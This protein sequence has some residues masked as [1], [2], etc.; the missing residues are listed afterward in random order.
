M[1]Y[2]IFITGAS[3]YIGQ[4]LVCKLINNSSY[5]LLLLQSIK[6]NRNFISNKKVKYYFYNKKGFNLKKIFL[7]EKPDVVIHLAAK[8]FIDEYKK[9]DLEELINSNIIFSINL[10]DAM[11]QSG[12]KKIINTGTYWEQYY[13]NGKYHPVNFYA[14]FKKAFQD[15]LQYYVEVHDFRAI[16]LRLYDIYGQEDK[17]KKII[18]ILLKN[19]GTRKLINMSEGEQYV[20][21]I[22]INDVILSYSKSIEYVLKNKIPQNVSVDVGSGKPIKLKQCILLIEKIFQKNLMVNLGARPYRQREVMKVKANLKEAKRIINWKPTIS[23]QKGLNMIK[24]SM[25]LK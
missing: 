9:N 6:S 10:L 12:I 1:K 16:T 7:K 13:Q 14:S 8:S 20:D 25:K 2:K 18:P 3:G 17:R 15:I 11:R 24:E 5:S 19:I 22:H 23:I 4:Q 21:F